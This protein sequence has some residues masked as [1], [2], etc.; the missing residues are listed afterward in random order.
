MRTAAV[1]L[2]H[3]NANLVREAIVT[4][5]SPL[6]QPDPPWSSGV[7]NWVTGSR[8]RSVNDAATQQVATP[9]RM[10]LQHA[11]ATAIHDKIMRR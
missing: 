2:G 5:A 1:M 10:K 11:G 7:L 3:L 9:T 4:I 8:P 6:P